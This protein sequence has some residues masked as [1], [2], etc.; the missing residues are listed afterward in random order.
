MSELSI[1]V[2]IAGRQ[3]PLTIPREEEEM[4][5]K[6]AKMVDEQFRFFTENYAV[7]DRAD[8]LA[9]VALQMATSAVKAKQN[10]E[11]PAQTDELQ[12]ISDMLS[13]ALS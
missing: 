6:A 2:K 5:R 4:V 1:K 10:S 12:E 9:M 8:L 13:D 3:F 11:D 7:Q